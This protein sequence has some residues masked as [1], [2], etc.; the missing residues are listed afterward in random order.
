M[1]TKLNGILK[2]LW[3]DT[4]VLFGQVYGMIM[5]KKSNVILVEGI[6]LNKDLK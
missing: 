4:Y 1:N 3:S 2:I 6:K 5:G